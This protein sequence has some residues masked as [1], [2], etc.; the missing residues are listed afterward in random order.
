VLNNFSL[1][2]SFILKKIK[3]SLLGRGKNLRKNV[4]YDDEDEEFEET[5]EASLTSNEQK[6]DCE[7]TEWKKSPC[8]V[9]C[10][11]GYRFKSR[12]IIVSSFIN[13]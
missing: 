2:F 10:G 7:V 3:K 5:R 12:A 13:L 1:N 4:R 6:I 9:T 8:N 11:E